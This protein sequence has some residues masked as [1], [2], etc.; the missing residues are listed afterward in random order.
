MYFTVCNRNGPISICLLGNSKEEAIEYWKTLDKQAYIDDA[1][2]SIEDYFEF[3]G[4]SMNDLEFDQA[5]IKA[6]AHCIGSLGEPDRHGRFKDSDW[7][8]WIVEEY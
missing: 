5:L 2:S 1:S 8:L 4:S 3:D 6:G 7:Y